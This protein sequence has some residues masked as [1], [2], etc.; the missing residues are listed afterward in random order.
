[1]APERRVPVA[2]RTLGCKVNRVESEDVAA[3]LIGRGAVLSAEDEAAVIVVNTCTVTGEADAKARK[4]VRRA[5][6]ASGS[7]LVVVTGCLASLD[8]A[9]LSALG[10]RV[11]VEADKERVAARVA[12]HLALAGAPATTPVRAGQGFRTRAPL[13]VQDGCDNFCAYCI[14]PHARGNPRSVPLDDVLR[15][16]RGL[17]D[18]GARELVLTGINVGRY[19][20][21]VADLAGLVRA[22]AAL[23]PWR[24]R[25]S[26]IEPPDLT[27]DLLAALAEAGVRHLHV[28]LQSGSDRVLAAMGRRYTAAEY[29]ALIDP[30]RF[31]GPVAITTDVMVGFP[32]ESAEDVAATGDVCERAG[33]T[34]LHVFRYSVRSGTPAASMSGQV[35]ATDKAA[36]AALLRETGDALRAAHVARAVGRA[37][38]LLVESVDA[39]GHAS[40]TTW[41]YL[42]VGFVPAGAL[43]GEIVRVRLAGESGGV[44]LGERE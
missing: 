22:L 12:E 30:A 19:R 29:L 6:K 40:A 4:A 25:L 1:V 16:A 9:G 41:D 7:P 15:T 34:K 33:F 32:G 23:D 31:E 17:L 20:D 44:L 27:D 28:P 18:A 36:R 35:S 11:V 42:R 24:I 2:F 39:D 37:E 5:L 8:P 10:D 26:S 14:V 38:D 13:K 21:G 43:P 3:D